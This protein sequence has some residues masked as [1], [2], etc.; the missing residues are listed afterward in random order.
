ME[1]EIRVVYVVSARDCDASIMYAVFQSRRFMWDNDASRVSAEIRT[2]KG[3][4]EW[5]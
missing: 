1:S 3:E 5:D 4:A 2:G